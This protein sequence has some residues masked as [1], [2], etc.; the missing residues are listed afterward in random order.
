MEGTWVCWSGGNFFDRIKFLLRSIF[1]VTKR[2]DFSLDG[3][4][5]RG[6]WTRFHLFEFVMDRLRNQPSLLRMWTVFLERKHDCKWNQNNKFFRW[7]FRD[8]LKCLVSEQEEETTDFKIF[9]E[10]IMVCDD[11]L[12]PVNKIKTTT[13]RRYFNVGNLWSYCF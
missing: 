1:V 4:H 8:K 6:N 10:K 7:E 3:L 5:R 11:L 13:M 9:I 2:L 12:L